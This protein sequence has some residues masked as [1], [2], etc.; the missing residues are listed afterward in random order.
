MK[1]EKDSCK[2][3]VFNALY[4]D[5]AQSLRN[6]VFFKCTDS[7]QSH[8][9]TQEAF[10][11]LWKNCA[12]VTPSKAKS[13]L[14]TVANNLFL[15]SVAHQKVVLNFRK[16]KGSGLDEQSPQFL[17]EEKE[18]GERL[19]KAIDNLTEMQRT[20]F[21]LSRVEGKKY[22]EIA[23]ILNISEK[24][25]GKRIHDAMEALRRQIDKI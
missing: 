9:I 14:Y 21:L 12:K 2:E 24:A 18:Y 19:F 22:K 13:F 11:K 16:T 15:N 7:A 3:E 17:L 1:N 6:F 8:D 10:I 20:A 23:E 25:A 4:R 5:Y